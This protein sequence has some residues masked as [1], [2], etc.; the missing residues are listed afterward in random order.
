MP[1]VPCP[2]TAP[3]ATHILPFVVEKAFANCVGP[4]RIWATA[5][6]LSLASK[7]HIL[8]RCYMPVCS[9]SAR[10]YGSNGTTQ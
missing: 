9:A 7:L 10:G 8:L 4:S 3:P 1:G 6:A 5:Y 2:V